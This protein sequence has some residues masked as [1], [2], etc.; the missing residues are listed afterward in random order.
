MADHEQDRIERAAM[1]TALAKMQ[2]EFKTIPHNKLVE[3]RKKGTGTL[4]YSYDYTTYDAMLDFVRPIMAKHQFSL[5]NSTEMREKGLTLTAVLMYAN[6]ESISSTLPVKVTGNAQDLGSELSYMKRYAAACVL[7]LAFEEEDDDANPQ[8]RQPDTP[9]PAPARSKTAP[10][11]P[12]D[13]AAKRGR[14]LWK[15]T[16]DTGKALGMTDSKDREALLRQVVDEIAGTDDG[17]KP[18]S[19]K[20]LSPEEHAKIIA[21]LKEMEAQNTPPEE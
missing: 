15:V 20:S 13:D 19:T 1:A 18:R 2:A 10:P 6:G 11:S 17:G 9:G 12:Q 4:Q 16:N 14:H 3:V 5:T 21:K 8:N 7:G